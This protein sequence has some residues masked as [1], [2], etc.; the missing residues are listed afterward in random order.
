[1]KPKDENKRDN[2]VNFRVSSDEYEFLRKRAETATEGNIAE[3]IRTIVFP[4]TTE[5]N[6]RV[7]PDS[8]MDGATT[9]KGKFAINQDLFLDNVC[10]SLMTLPLIFR[11]SELTGGAFTDMYLIYKVDDN[12]FILVAYAGSVSRD[13][14]MVKWLNE[15]ECYQ[16]IEKH[17]GY[18]A[19]NKYFSHMIKEKIEGD[20][21]N[22]NVKLWELE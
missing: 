14:F 7:F 3:Y 22:E 16:Y 20:S 10:Y 12:R 6:K 1:M 17:N 8:I 15:S 13:E 9:I 4:V 5:G 18:N 2:Q 21:N 19:I 11:Y